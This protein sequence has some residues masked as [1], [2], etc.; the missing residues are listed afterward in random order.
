MATYTK[1]FLSPSTSGQPITVAG[2]NTAG[3]TAIHVGPSGTAI[4]ELWLHA[5]ISGAASATLNL[6]W[7]AATSGATIP[8]TITPGQGP[9]LVA[10]GWIISGQT[11]S[12]W[13]S[14]ASVV[15]ITGFGNR[16]S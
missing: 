6:L 11:V 8:V 1:I 2:T 4:D 14:V 7:G 15:T 10:P 9:I 5:S 13:A 16:I 12:A 3:A